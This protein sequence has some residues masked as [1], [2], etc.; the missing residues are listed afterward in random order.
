[1]GLTNRSRGES[2]QDHRSVF[3]AF[4]LISKLTLALC[5]TAALTFPAEADTWTRE[6]EGEEGVSEEFFYSGSYALVIGIDDYTNGWPKLANAVNDAKAV[7]DALESIG[8]EVELAK[9]LDLAALQSTLRSFFIK[10]G[11]ETPTPVSSSGTRVT[12]TPLMARAFLVP[13][14][15]PLGSDADFKLA[16]LHMRDFGSHVRLAKA[17]HVM[18]IFDSCFSGTIF[19]PTRAAPP[20]AIT[21]AT[22]RPVRQFLSSGDAE[23]TVL[24]DG[25]FRQLF[26]DALSG[27][28]PA[29][30][31][32]DGYLIGSELGLFMKQRLTNL[33]DRRQIPQ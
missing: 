4:G 12:V 16:S 32:G 13:A 8:F 6:T 7:A 17:K 33:T 3:L 25:T 2:L 1:V 11:Q 26:V 5:V 24:D 20:P 21:F 23:Q 19:N 10:R 18:A 9:N 14:D 30:A 22:A 31:N 27:I 29:D 15:A 28:E